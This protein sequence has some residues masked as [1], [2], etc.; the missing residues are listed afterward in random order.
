LLFA[1]RE[2]SVAL[3]MEYGREKDIKKTSARLVF[4]SVEP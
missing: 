1:T 4:I 2:I 3:A